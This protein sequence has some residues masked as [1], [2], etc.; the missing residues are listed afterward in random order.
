MTGHESGDQVAPPALAS[1]D[2]AELNRLSAKL[3][4]LSAQ[5]RALRKA[6][7]QFGDDFDAKAWTDAFN[8]P[9]SDDINRVYTVTGGY[10]ALVN[11]TAEAMR[12]GAK[13]TGT[14]LTAGTHGAPGIINAIR[15]DGGFT[16]QQ[17]E[18]F[19]ELYRTR[20]H[21]QHASPDIQAD[22]VHRQVRLLLGHL[23]RLVKS[24][25]AWLKSHDVEL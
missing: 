5:S 23:P 20:N 14:K 25:L 24:Y 6:M 1:I 8:S 9:D 22:E 15:A 19:T 16:R 12:A 21:L 13:L 3:E 11:N 10:L 18:T 2:T 7:L 17:A 4:R